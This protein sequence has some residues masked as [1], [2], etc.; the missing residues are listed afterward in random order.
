MRTY[1]Y[2]HIG[3]LALKHLKHDG[4]KFWVTR[5]QR[6]QTYIPIPC[7]EQITDLVEILLR[8]NSGTSE[9]VGAGVGV[10]LPPLVERG[11]G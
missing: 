6:V 9:T 11:R 4:G 10:E 8:K 3:E 5:A 1:E 2:K 7:P